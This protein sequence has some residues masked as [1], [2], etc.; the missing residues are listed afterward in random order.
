MKPQ[1]RVF[2]KDRPC[3]KLE[4]WEAFRGPNGFVRVPVVEAQAIIGVNVP[5]VMEREGRL[6]IETVRGVEYYVLT[7]EGEGWLLAGFTS[8]TRNHPHAASKATYPLNSNKQN[9]VRRVRR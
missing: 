1:P 3:T 7:D 6:V 2:T 9:R 5:R 8:Y 4:I